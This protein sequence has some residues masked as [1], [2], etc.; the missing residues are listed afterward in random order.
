MRLNVHVLHLSLLNALYQVCDVSS[1]AVSCLLV[2]GDCHVLHQCQIVLEVYAAS[3]EI[4]LYNALCCVLDG[5]SSN[6]SHEWDKI[7]LKFSDYLLKSTV[8]IVCDIVLSLC[9]LLSHI[10]SHGLCYSVPPQCL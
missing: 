3:A 10:H 2:L 4:F 6:L 8:P 9:Y 7:L 5:S 1:H